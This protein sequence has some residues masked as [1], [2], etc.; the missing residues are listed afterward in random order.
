M[1]KVSLLYL[2]LFFC[3]SA[4]SLAQDATIYNSSRGL[5]NSQIQTLYEDSRHN[6][7]ITTRNGLNRFD[8][9]KMNV[10]RHSAKDSTSLLHDITTCVFEYDRQ[11]L[12]VGTDAGLQVYDYDRDEFKNVRCYDLTGKQVPTHVIN[13]VRLRSGKI[14][15][16]IGGEGV[17]RVERKG[18]GNFVARITR[19]FNTDDDMSPIQVYE[20]RYGTVWVISSGGHLFKK[21]R[22]KMV[23]VGDVGNFR[24]MCES[25]SGRLFV[26]SFTEGLYELER[27]KLRLV[28]VGDDKS[29]F[30]IWSIS[31]WSDGRVFIC[32][33]GGGLKVYDENSGVVSQTTIHS[34]EF[35]LVNSNIKDV[36]C[37]SYGNIWIGVYWKGVIRK[38]IY[39][40]PFE[41][42]G[43]LS[44]TKNSIGANSVTAMSPASDGEIWIATDNC[45]LSKMTADGTASLNWSPSVTENMPS[46]INAICTDDENGRIWL[47]S[48]AE[49]LRIMDAKTHRISK[50]ERYVPHVFDIKKDGV[51]GVWIATL[52]NGVYHY[53]PGT[54]EMINYV[55]SHDKGHGKIGNVYISCLQTRDN[56]LYVG[57]SDALEVYRISGDM[58]LTLK[59]KVLSSTYIN[60]IVFHGNKIL[61]ATNKGLYVINDK[62]EAES[63]YDVDKGLSNNVVNS[64]EI[65]DGCVWLSTDNGLSR[66]DLKTGTFNNFFAEDGLQDNEFGVRTSMRL[67]ETLYFG[68]ISGLNYFEDNK[69]SNYTP[70]KEFKLRLV[71]LYV[72]GKRVYK[73][74]E[75]GYNSILS[76]NIDDAERVNLAYSDNHFTL[77]MVADGV[78]NHS[79]IYEYSIDGHEWTSQNIQSNSISVSYLKTG[80]HTLRLRARC[81][82]SLSEERQ[83][84]V[85]VHSPWYSSVWAC[86]VYLLI[87]FCMAWLAYS[88][89]MRRIHA[90]RLLA[91]HKKEEEMNEARIQF[92]M[93]ISHEIRTP[94]TLIFAPLEKLMSTD[95]DEFHQHNYSL[96]HQNAKRI[97]R[98]INQMMDVR[99]IEK[100]QYKLDYKALDVVDYVQNIYDVFVVNAQ[101]RH[102]SFTYTHSS[103][104]RYVMTDPENLD[105][106][107]MNLLGNAFKF[108]PDGGEIDL[109]LEFEGDKMLIKVTDSGNGV[110]DAEKKR[111]FERFYSGSHQN[112]YIGTGIGLNL[113]YLIVRLFDG[114]IRVEDNP[115]GHG[116]VFVVSLPFG[117]TQVSNV[118]QEFV[119]SVR[120]EGLEAPSPSSNAEKAK[121]L[122][123]RNV[124]VVEDD[125][126]IRSYVHAELSADM[127]VTEFGD[128]QEGWDYVV[129][130]PD[131]VD[132][133]I[134]DVMMPVMDGITLCSKIK[135]N[136]NTSHIPVILITALSDDAD[137]IKG[138]DNGA[139]A[140][141][142]KPFN[143][144]VLRSTALNILNTR[145]LLQGKYASDDKVEKQIEKRDLLSPD[146]ILLNRVI[147]V[148]NDNMDDPELSVEIVADKV[149]IS[150]V[151]FYRKMKELTGQSPRDFLKSVR[152]KEA[153]RLLSEKNLDITSVCA[154]TGFKSLST[155]SSSFKAAY[156]RSPSEYTK[157]NR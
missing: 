2:V 96:I 145:L 21:V 46:T 56:M 13:M 89:A 131:K 1:K 148:I 41:Y 70:N 104:S 57:L 151:H 63:H 154:A 60:D 11:H 39:Q 108:T 19:E 110:S 32:S 58:S 51:G 101:S 90:K 141:V 88:Q 68:G 29:V 30:N 103:D 127:N 120:S 150:R 27:D 136:F 26:C 137:R 4:L 74:D 76:S 125:A 15:A 25:S 62:F 94:M 155:F 123:H 100:G 38:P 3:V 135:H 149:G 48:Y 59:K 138:T 75:S 113:T 80:E 132:L 128:G 87:F 71:D 117:E 139:D 14:Y 53:N 95:S 72:S 81:N 82:Q 130:N 84:V 20:D 111:I 6:I 153:A 147:K 115:Q 116:A 10:Y 143:I 118:S 146:E 35:N 8:G 65:C 105:K 33:D 93:N 133:V 134:S 124:I 73:G 99:K 34:T 79:V 119:T 12:F 64:I 43:K 66:L 55:S 86:C 107:L 22:D 152:L 67:G 78:G 92:F 69:V 49:G 42:V 122:R 17:A 97:M 102:I 36:L 7:W 91:K 157:S 142:T 28:R 52:S 45:G 77:E 98:L 109:S 140:Y 16:C 50:V 9:V 156:G 61:V 40:S 129:K 54:R 144:D 37:D 23:K 47:G 5:S 106:I 85:I 112:G 114:E 126:T 83:I 24:N 44:I 18:D 31:P 121:G